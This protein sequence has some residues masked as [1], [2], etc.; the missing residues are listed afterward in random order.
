MEFI[1]QL[2]NAVL[3]VFIMATMLSAG[4]NTTFEQVTSVFKRWQLVLS[5]LVVGFLIRPLVG[6]GSAELFALATPA[7]IATVLIWS[8]PG[9]PFG[10]SLVMTAKASI[11]TG[12]VLQ[13]TMAA[14][15]S[16]TF[17]PTANALISVADLG[18]GVSLPVADLVLTVAFLQLVPFAVGILTRHWTEERARAWEVTSSK[19]ASSTFV[20]VLAG[21]LLGSWETMVDLVGSRTLLAAITASVVMIA[22]G[23]FFA[24]GGTPTKRATALI[25]PCSNSGP[26]FAAIG[27]AFNND[28][29]ILGAA[30][31]VLVLQIVTG[32]V[33]ASF[34]GRNAEGE[35]VDATPAEAAA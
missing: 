6:W 7:F 27:I 28:P 10:S 12:A 2:F 5:V 29:E 33:V 1:Q 9:A 34:W 35:S 11:Q 8:C 24:P 19:V 25:Q 26:A 4:F 14:I 17:A 32:V 23:Y 16:I 3:V 21:A 13:V 31:A 15:G 22:V 18:D 30:T 20:V